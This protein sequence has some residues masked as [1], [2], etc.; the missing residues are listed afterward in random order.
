MLMKLSLW[1]LSEPLLRAE[2]MKCLTSLGTSAL[3]I[4][5]GIGSTYTPALL[6][7]NRAHQHVR[8]VGK[9]IVR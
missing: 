5:P 2:L 3:Y 8:E 7:V 1:Q 9:T 6:P 4:M